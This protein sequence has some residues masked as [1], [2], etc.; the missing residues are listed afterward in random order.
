MINVK[1]QEELFRLIADYLDESIECLAVG[2]TAMMFMGYK[3]TT[4]DIDL[5]F[6]SE[7]NRKTFIRAIEKL[8]YSQTSSRAIYQDEK[9][10][11]KNIPL[12]YSRGQE[13][14]DLFAN[15]VLGFEIEFKD[16][17]QR[18]DYIGKKELT[19]FTAPKELLII[20]KS[21]TSREKDFED[22][23]AIVQME[24]N[25]DWE[26]IVNE[27]IRMR[28]K[29]RWILIDLEESMKKLKTKA[30]I[31][32]EHFDRLYKAEEK[33]AKNQPDQKRQ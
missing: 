8:G 24:K 15:D 11:R 13:R 5:V 16:F 28:K 17:I 22:I 12:I 23:E 19:L 9:L 2:G 31:K 26:K 14:F 1:D 6:K 18:H 29:S 27:A 32:Q 21:V 33:H 7:E 4:K 20:L 25:I 10:K 30:F 3:A